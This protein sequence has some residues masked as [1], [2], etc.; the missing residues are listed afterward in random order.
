MAPGSTRKSPEPAPGAHLRALSKWLEASEDALARDLQH[1]SNDESD[2]VELAKLL[3]STQAVLRRVLW[4]RNQGDQRL[5]RPSESL[6]SL[7]SDGGRVGESSPSP[8][9]RLPKINVA[10]SGSLPQLR[11]TANSRVKAA[12]LSSDVVSTYGFAPI[13]DTQVVGTDDV[14]RLLKPLASAKG[15]YIPPAASGLWPQ[16]RRRRAVRQRP[17][18]PDQDGANNPSPIPSRLHGMRLAETHSLL[19][20]VDAEGNAPYDPTALHSTTLSDYI[21][22]GGAHNSGRTRQ[23]RIG[24]RKAERA[25]QK[26]LKA[27]R[28]VDAQ[29]AARSERMLQKERRSN[30]RA[31]ALAFVGGL[32]ARISPTPMSDEI[33]A[34]M[35][36]AAVR[37]MLG[38]RKAQETRRLRTRC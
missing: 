25:Q 3:K 26:A 20:G 9:Q 31:M 13:D 35:L 8:Q 30:N 16:G 28:D 5:P 18:T 24:L 32:N 17:P 29:A 38:R 34:L 22:H 6:P 10:S 12:P 27:L 7:R 4:Q 23:D 2:H 14:K 19:E 33:A 37:G 36:Q 15:G 11:D 21:R 1:L